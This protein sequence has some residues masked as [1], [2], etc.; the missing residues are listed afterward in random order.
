MDALT[1][2]RSEHPLGKAIWS[3]YEKSGGKNEAADDFKV[4]AGQGVSAVVDGKTVLAG[5]EGFMLT[6]GIDVSACA[7]PCAS[8][9]SKGATVVFV[10]ADKEL[11]G[12]IALRDT[13][14]E[15][16]KLRSKS[17]NP[18]ASRQCF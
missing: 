10:A 2:Q 13:L 14:R 3:A 9:L 5:K 8:E 6:Q 15:D 7:D 4:I 11:I 18:R 17:F 16:A 12:F 1:E